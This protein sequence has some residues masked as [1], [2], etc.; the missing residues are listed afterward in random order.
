[1]VWMVSAVPRPLD[2][3]GKTRCPSY[4]RLDGPQGRSAQVQ[5]LVPPRQD[6]IPLL[7]SQ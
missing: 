6:S 3:L 2:P 5:E 1:M 4:M 7:P